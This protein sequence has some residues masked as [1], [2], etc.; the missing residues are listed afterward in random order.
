MILDFFL[1]MLAII[2]ILL[3]LVESRNPRVPA[4]SRLALVYAARS[5]PPLCPELPLSAH[6]LPIHP[7]CATQWSTWD[8][9]LASLLA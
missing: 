2:W 3:N 6:L 9:G 4:D 1:D 8:L 5:T 7:A